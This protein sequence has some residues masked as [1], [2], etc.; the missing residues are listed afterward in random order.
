MSKLIKN[1]KMIA[2]P[3]KIKE[4]D[5]FFINEEGLIKKEIEDDNFEIIDLE[6]KYISPGWIDLH[7]HIYYGV[8]N[9]G[10]DPNLIGPK[11]GVTVL[12]DAGSAGEATFLGFKK[13]IIESNNFPIYSFINIGSTGLIKSNKIS[14]FKSLNHL[15]LDRLYKVIIENPEYIKGIKL[16]ASG[17]ILHGF[18]SDIVKL[19]KELAK[20]VSL[21][22][23]VHVGEPLPLLEDIL[24]ALDSGDVVT[25]IFHGKRWGIYR[26]HKLLPE[27][28]EAAAR[29]VKF[30]VGHG[31]ESFNFN[32]GKR[33][34]KEGIRPD[35]IGTDIHHVNINGPVWDLALTISKFLNIGM[36][37]E[38]VIKAV[39]INAADI[40]KID[41][42]QN[43]FFDHQARFTVF[44]IRES[45]IE[46]SDSNHNNLSLNKYIAP[47]E[48]ILLNE[49][50]KSNTRIDIN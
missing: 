35:T 46:V 17:E 2:F 16:R 40:L 49:R 30:D 3:E 29:G 44:N 47:T 39:T 11:T 1:F 31:A 12:N 21:P 15:D 4:I 8:S 45:N 36:N 42:Y 22:L 19:A 18:N 50:I 37:L 20:E 25:H 7:T 13:Y 14:E 24:P 33:A 10:V 34:I 38:E 28:K 26:N 6:G 23:M 32:V 9:L 5:Q 27:F 41:S 48:V 43:G